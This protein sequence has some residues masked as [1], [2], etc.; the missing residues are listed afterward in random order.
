M[1]DVDKTDGKPIMEVTGTYKSGDTLPTD[2]IY[3]GSWMLN[4]SDK[5]VVFFDGATSTWG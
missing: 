5:S 1:A 2:H 4:L 3:Q